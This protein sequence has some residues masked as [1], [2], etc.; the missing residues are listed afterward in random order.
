MTHTWERK[1]LTETD[2]ERTQMLN[3]LSQRAKISNQ[4][5]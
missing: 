5:L 3:S 2:P 4:L 1:Q